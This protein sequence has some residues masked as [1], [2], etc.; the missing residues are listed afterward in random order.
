MFFN[1]L[2]CSFGQVLVGTG[3]LC[4]S[5]GEVPDGKGDGGNGHDRAKDDSEDGTTAQ[6][7]FELAHTS[8]DIASSIVL[9]VCIFGSS[10]LAAFIGGA[11]VAA[12]IL[13][14]A[15]GLTVVV[16]VARFR[17]RASSVN[18]GSDSGGVV[19]GPG[20]S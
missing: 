20:T 4:W 7:V 5:L 1:V 2:L 12:A 15:G 17:I 16:V 18:A 3:G 9:L 10:V 13:A 19:F 8:I 11:C 6:T 14:K